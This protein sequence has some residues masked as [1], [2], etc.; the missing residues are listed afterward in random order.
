MLTGLNK[1]PRPD[2]RI[3]PHELIHCT[4][5]CCCALDQCLAV[6]DSSCAGLSTVN[7]AVIAEGLTV[8]TPAAAYP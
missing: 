1:K 7:C 8:T 5:D 3:P 4:R 6:I 2:P